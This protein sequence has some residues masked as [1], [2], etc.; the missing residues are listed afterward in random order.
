MRSVISDAHVAGNDEISFYSTAISALRAA[1]LRRLRS[2][3]RLRA[4][5]GRWNSLQEGFDSMYAR[6]GFFMLLV[7][8]TPEPGAGAPVPPVPEVP[9]QKKPQAETASPLPGSYGA[10][11]RLFGVGA[12]AG[13][14]GLLWMQ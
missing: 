7:S 1:A 6:H 4:Q 9:E 3:T 8:P 13:C 14:H 12:S 2:E 5:C 10:P 11:P